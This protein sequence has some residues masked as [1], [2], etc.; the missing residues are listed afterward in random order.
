MN[1]LLKWTVLT[2]IT[3]GCLG[4]VSQKERDDL[5]TSYRRAQEH[6]E[7]LKA[8]LEESQARIAA[9]EAAKGGDPE[10]AEK[11]ARAQMENAEYARRLAAL[12]DQ[13]R[14]MGL[15]PIDPVVDAALIE[16]A[17]QYPDLMSYDSSRGMIRMSSD[18]TFA[19]GS[20]DVSD[21][22][23]ASLSRLAQVLNTPAASKYEVRTVGHTDNVPVT[24][25]AG[26]QRFGDNW[27][28][29][30]ARAISVMKALKA[31]GVSESRMGVGGYGE[32]R[33]VVANPAVGGRSRGAEANRRVEIYLVPMP[34]NVPT[35]EAAPAG[36]VA[37]PAEEPPARFK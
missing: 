35:V 27:G 20:A 25:A 9:L 33:P 19:L 2:T 7:E 31:A 18:L 12:E 15:G 5:Q 24:S 8:R 3:L 37:T 32:M 10:L 30:T 17:K 13:I 36:E 11:L 4:C 22:A 21:R 26:R 28:L 14:R 1:A 6:I 16:L 29:S 23:K 34:A